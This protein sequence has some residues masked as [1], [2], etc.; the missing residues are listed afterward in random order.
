MHACEVAD[1]ISSVMFGLIIHDRRL[2]HADHDDLLL[3]QA[4]TTKQGC[5]FAVSEQ[6][7]YITCISCMHE[8]NIQRL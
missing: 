2:H 3:T 7:C 8:L 1:S 4:D 5:G 6:Q